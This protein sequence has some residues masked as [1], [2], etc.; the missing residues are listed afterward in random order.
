MDRRRDS[1]SRTKFRARAIDF[2]D[3]SVG[4]EG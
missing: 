3:P 1:G 2:V 4:S